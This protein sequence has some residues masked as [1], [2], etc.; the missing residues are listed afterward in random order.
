[1][2]PPQGSHGDGRFAYTIHLWIGSLYVDCVPWSIQDG[3]PLNPGRLRCPSKLEVAAFD[4]AVRRGDLLWAGSPM[5][6]DA[7]V[8]GDPSLFEALFDIAAA[9]N[10]RYN[11]TKTARV[12]SNVDVPGFARSSIPL[13][14]QAGAAALSICANVGNPHQGTGAVPRDFVDV[15][16][17]ASMW[18]WHD[19]ASDEEILVLYHKAQRDSPW[20]I[21]ITSEFNTY[22]GFTRADNTL[23][24]PTGTAFASFIGADKIFN[25]GMV[26]LSR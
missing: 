15:S 22:G 14:K 12:W 4:A 8:V 16:T 21:P 19:P 17:N 5:N 1:M 25:A 20:K 6:M 26:I 11:I 2:A 10:E 18:R 3:C 13:L 24:T 7:G 9:L 23:V